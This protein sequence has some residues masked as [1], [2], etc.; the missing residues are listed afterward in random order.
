MKKLILTVYLLLIPVC[1]AF[2]Q[3]EGLGQLSP[4]PIWPGD[5]VIPPELSDKYVFLDPEAGQ[6]ILAYPEGL[7]QP[8]TAKTGQM[9]IERLNL[10]NQVKASLSVAVAKN[11]G[12]YVYR[13]TVENG[14]GAR[15]PIKKFDIPVPDLGQDDEVF[16]P[17]KW[18]GAKAETQIRALQIATGQPS[19]FF[20]SWYN[21]DE[22]ERKDGPAIKAGE[23]LSGFH[24]E[25]ELKP[26]ITMAYVGTGD[27]PALHG[28]MPQSVLEQAAPLMSIEANNQNVL[29]VGP[30]FPSDTHKLIIA[31]DFHLGIS[32]MVR[33][34][35]LDGDS[36]AIQEALQVLEYYLKA[37][38]AAEGAELEDFVGPRMEFTEKPR[39]GLES[40]V[41]HALT[42][43]LE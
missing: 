33:H 40:D 18:Q 32:R 25:S 28:A 35:Q 6:M 17:K 23:K 30:K 10:G 2:A 12:K 31:G 22:E 27:Y 13:Y 7:G 38:E 3:Q 4:V 43:G 15:R 24:I 5:D 1:T 39:P 8:N 14:K 9:H 29:T 37:A 42:V 21:Y 19:G 11:K 34:G 16:S 36:P 20:L 41:L 26:G